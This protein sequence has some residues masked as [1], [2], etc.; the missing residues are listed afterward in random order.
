MWRLVDGRDDE[1][2]DDK[3][4]LLPGG[5]IDGHLHP[6][7]ASWSRDGDDLLFHN[8]QGLVTTRFSALPCRNGVQLWRGT[9]TPNP[10]ITHVLEERAIGWPLT[11]G[12]VSWLPLAPAPGRHGELRPP[13]IIEPGARL[14]RPPIL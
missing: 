10:S 6:N 7:E 5:R 13:P 9:F 2:I 1:G 8:V 11:P 4:R 14:H 12:Y 3:L